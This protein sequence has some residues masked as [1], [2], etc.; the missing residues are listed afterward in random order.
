MRIHAARVRIALCAVLCLLLCVFFAMPASAAGRIDLASNGSLDVTFAHSSAPLA[1]VP[2]RIYRVADFAA[3]GALSLTD[4]FAALSVDFVELDQ[5]AW[6]NLAETL[7]GYVI[8]EEIAVEQEKATDE[9]GHVL[10]EGLKPG[11]YLLVGDTALTKKHYYTPM[12]ALVAVP[13][14][15]EDDR[16]DYS[17][18][19]KIKYE[20]GERD[21]TDITVV[22]VWR[23]KGWAPLRPEYI[24]VHLYG[25]GEKVDEV[26]L[27]KYNNWRYEWE[28]LDGAVSWKVVE[29]PVPEDYTVEITK[30]G[31]VIT[32]INS[33]PPADE[34]DILPQTGLDWW[35]VWILAA[36]GMTLFALGWL[37][38]RKNEG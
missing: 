8:A 27:N 37:R 22:K 29:K 2:F 21:L 20:S 38:S 34:D 25:N 16:W 26:K 19:V 12:P 23:D 31:K 6:R 13:A 33:R 18:E 5:A 17:Q 3:S 14:T 30:D 28:D 1:D 32:I 36:L 35:P 15:D 7:S 4:E 9:T 24:K 11:I 10:F